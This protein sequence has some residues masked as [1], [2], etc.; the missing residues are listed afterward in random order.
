MGNMDDRI[1]DAMLDFGNPLLGG[2]KFSKSSSSDRDGEVTGY[3]M[4]QADSMDAS[5]K[6]L[7]WTSSFSYVRFLI[8]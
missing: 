3:S 8:N 2:K 4:I 6:T 5:Y 7:G 1:S